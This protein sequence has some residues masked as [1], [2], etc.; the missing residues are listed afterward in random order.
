MSLEM[1]VRYQEKAPL[2]H[3][4]RRGREEN[5]NEL[6]ELRTR[7]ENR[8]R[9]WKIACLLLL[10]VGILVARVHLE[11]P[12]RLHKLLPG[13]TL[14]IANY[15]T[16]LQ[17]ALQF[18]DVQKCRCCLSLSLSL[19]LSFFRSSSSS[20]LGFVELLLCVLGD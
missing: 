7:N 3:N 2:A 5:E 13:S 18:L 17:L 12:H 11:R 6:G 10:G 20:S 15:T 9:Y 14:S 1:A 8:G 4:T 19:S 16:A